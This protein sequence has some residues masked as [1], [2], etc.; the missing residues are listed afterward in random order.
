MCFYRFWCLKTKVST[1]KRPNSWTKSRQ[2]SQSP[3]HLC[4]G[5]SISAT[6]A[7]SYYC[8]RNPYRNLKSENSQDYAQKPQRNCMFMN[9]ATV[10]STYMHYKLMDYAVW[11]IWCWNTHSLPCVYESGS[12]SHKDNF[13][14]SLR[15]LSPAS[16]KHGSFS[17]LI[18]PSTKGFLSQSYRV[19]WVSLLFYLC[20]Y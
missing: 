2:K 15:F 19:D 18:F 16:H 8:L 7:T 10:H 3:L 17:D 4:L 5:I 14:E 13:D 9:S 1:E 12:G 6:H 11:N 20:L